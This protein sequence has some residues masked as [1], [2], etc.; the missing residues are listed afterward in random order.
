MLIDRQSRPW[1]ILTIVLFLAATVLYF[2]YSHSTLHG[3][4][5]SSW[6]GIAY[7][8][9]GTVFM[10]FAML[11]SLRKRLRTLRIGRAFWWTQGH[12]WLGLLSYPL[13]LY[14]AGFRW[15]QPFGLTWWLM[16]LFTLIVLSGIVGVVLQNIIPTKMLR[17]LPLETIYEQIDHV[18]L[19]L[20]READE[21]V[22]SATQSRAEEAFDR[23]AIPAGANLATLTH[24]TAMSKG[25]ALLQKFYNDEVK[26]FLTE[27]NPRRSPLLNLT[28]ASAAFDA[29]RLALPR[30]LHEHLNDLQDIVDERR[31][32]LRQRRLHH[33]LHGWLLIHVPLSFALTVLAVVHIVVALRYL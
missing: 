32:L 15:G 6:Q 13:I 12:V 20:S 33:L 4:S 26:P 18:S 1:I 21:I 31:Q 3:P 24:S 17:E 19:R 9:A 16:T 22:T 25:Q 11:L 7:G 2:P 30:E 23:E 10:A 8:I 28:T 5:G 27:R 14:H 29:V